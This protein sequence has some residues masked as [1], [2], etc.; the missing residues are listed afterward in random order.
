M[1]DLFHLSSI[2]S[3]R[4]LLGF[5]TPFQSSLPEARSSPFRLSPRPR[6][7]LAFH[8]SLYISLL[9]WSPS[10]L[11]SLVLPWT[12]VPSKLS[13]RLTFIAP[14]APPP[15]RPHL[16]FL[17][18]HLSRHFSH[19]DSPPPSDPYPPRPQSPAHTL[20]CHSTHGT[21]LLDPPSVRSGRA[22]GKSHSLPP[23]FPDSPLPTWLVFPGD[24]KVLRHR[25]RGVAESALP[26][27][28]RVLRVPRS[29]WSRD[30]G[31]RAS[32]SSSQPALSALRVAPWSRAP[33]TL[34]QAPSPVPSCGWQLWGRRRGSRAKRFFCS[35]PTPPPSL[36][37][38][39]AQGEGRPSLGSS[40][41]TMSLPC[42]RRRSPGS[43]LSRRSEEGAAW[44]RALP[45]APLSR[46]T[47]GGDSAG[48]RKDPR[49][50]RATLPGCGVLPCAPR[51]TCL[52]RSHRPR[53]DG[54]GHDGVERAGLV[55]DTWCPRPLG[56]A[57]RQGVG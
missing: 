36:P 44:G 47:D 43:I 5:S 21:S 35:Q 34:P 4:W 24:W 48:L 17:T 3:F 15:S 56:S 11:S 32:F 39:H 38:P 51:T 8:P 9:N 54:A 22:M 19:L 20:G 14:P 33:R 30:S 13:C 16:L 18:P 53:R 7:P 10:P 28:A 1:S 52:R 55:L 27:P 26:Q 25:A 37:H 41:R 45:L 49:S 40:S 57:A 31:T 46:R 50:P 6:A 29:R 12:L 2:T 23:T 42:S